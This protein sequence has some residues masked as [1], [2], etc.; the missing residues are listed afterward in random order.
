MPV[1]HLSVHPSAW[2]GSPPSITAASV[3]PSLPATTA[4]STF[5]SPTHTGHNTGAGTPAPIAPPSVQYSGP[6]PRNLQPGT[7]LLTPTALPAPTSVPGLAP[8][9][10]GYLNYVAYQHLGAVSVLRRGR[11]PEDSPPSGLAESKNLAKQLLTLW[12]YRW[13]PVFDE[14]YPSTQDES[15]GIK[16]EPA[17]IEWVSPFLR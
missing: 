5:P 3:N 1:V 4:T 15:A 2:A 6:S 7:N 14:E 16:Y 12:G 10:V 11:L 17:T 8:V 13:P 9:S